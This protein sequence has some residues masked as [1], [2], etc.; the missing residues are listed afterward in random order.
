MAYDHQLEA[1]IR[2]ESNRALRQGARS[3]SLL[4]LAALILIS[5]QSWGD[6]N[7]T[8]AAIFPLAGLLLAELV[9]LLAKRE[10]M[11]TRLGT[12]VFLGATC[13]PFV[14]LC[15]HAVVADFGAATFF[16]GPLTWSWLVIICVSAFLFDQRF[17]R[18]VGVLSGVLFLAGYALARPK[19]ES[20]PEMNA[21][22]RSAL[23]APGVQVIKAVLMVGLG[24]VAGGLASTAR[25]MVVRIRD[26]ERQKL[27]ISALFGQ[28]VSPEVREEVMRA[29]AGVVGERKV[30]AVLFSDLRGFTSFSE[31]AEPSEV[32]LRLNEYFDAMV[33]AVT[34]N[35][36]TVDKFIGDAVMAVFGGLIPLENPA[37]SALAAAR[38][39]RTE[40]ATLNLAWAARGL[41]GP[42]GAVERKEFTVIGDVVNTASRLE[43]ATKELGVAIVV[44]EAVAAQLSAEQRGTLR[45]LG[46]VKLKG[47][48]VEVQ[49]FGAS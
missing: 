6:P 7:F 22:F 3:A 39:M 17:S 9:H 8:P 12:A 45:P 43:S 48:A 30:V 21:A 49:V 44:S 10:Q 34:S 46:G 47:K 37:Q 19:L 24:F 28:Y 4:A 1:S 41:Q 36:G 35:G 25:A 11:H 16:F 26:E 20:L 32:V 13:M 33:R 2:V 38:A 29:K 27:S 31:K 5:A 23:V 18:I 42:I 14:T 15:I 40:L